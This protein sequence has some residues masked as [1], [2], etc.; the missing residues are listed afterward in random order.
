[1]TYKL[2]DVF[3]KNKSGICIISYWRSVLCIILGLL[4][5]H[6]SIAHRD[7]EQGEDEISV[8]IE[9][10]GLG[11]V[12]I[13]AV[14]HNKEVLLS[15]N[16]VFDFLKI[17]NTPSPAFD[18]ITGFYINQQDVFLIDKT[19]NRIYFKDKVYDLNATDLVRTESNL[20]LNLK[21]F[22]TVFDLD[23]VF[24]FRRLLVTL[25]SGVELPAIREMRLEVMRRNVSKLKGELKADTT[26]KRSYPLFHLGAADWA[27]VSTQQNLGNTDTRLNLGLGS[28]IAGG[29][30]NASLNYYTSSPLTE[31]QQYYQWHFV[32][33]DLQALRQ[34][35]AGKIY[36]PSIS[37][38]YAPLVGVQFNNTPT[39]QRRSYGTYT[40]S[41]TTEAGWIVEL[42]I[43]EVLVDYKKT[44]A[45]GFYSFEVPLIYGYSV[46]KLR[47]YGPWGEERTSQQYI[48]MCLSI[49]FHPANLNILSPAGLLKMATTAG[50]PV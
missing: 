44:D 39:I 28:I 31:K 14:I 38:L 21:Y 25:S 12:E 20:Y 9:V 47:F 36:T 33:N 11:G 26:L 30:A 17:R 49:F 24:I 8:T 41:N 23:G 2:A 32:N 1:M 15:V 6:Q 45:S 48:S 22:K 50:F 29:E 13:P 4:L 27:V 7:D 3:F 42:Y 5:S 10:K 40:L 16:S 34:V 35:S 37:S 19:Q 46:I 43:N 18:S